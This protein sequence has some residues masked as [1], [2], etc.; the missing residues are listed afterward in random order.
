MPKVS[1]LKILGVGTAQKKKFTMKGFFSKC[2]QI[3]M[4][5]WIWSHVLKKPLIE[6][7]IF[8]PCETY[9]LVTYGRYLE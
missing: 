3:R 5:L 6:N 8:V 4:K 9:L 1:F 2:E 7:F